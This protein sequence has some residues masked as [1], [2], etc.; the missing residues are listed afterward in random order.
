MNRQGIAERKKIVSKDD[1]LY[2][3][4]DRIFQK[5]Q[6]D[7]DREDSGFQGLVL[8]KGMSTKGMPTKGWQKGSSGGD[9]T[10]L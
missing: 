4:T 6:N 1:I 2:D 3:S 7:R 10:L 5:Q 8:A 9:R